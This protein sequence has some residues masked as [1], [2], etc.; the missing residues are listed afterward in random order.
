MW[1][2]HLNINEKKSYMYQCLF[3][4]YIQTK[5]TGSVESNYWLIGKEKD[6]F[7]TLV[8][9]LVMT[10]RVRGTCALKETSSRVSCQWWGTLKQHWQRLTL[11]PRYQHDN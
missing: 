2:H 10:R 1:L 4:L 5:V 7:Y 6:A 3:S 8:H 11:H 9:W